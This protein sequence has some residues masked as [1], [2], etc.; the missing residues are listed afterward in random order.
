MEP[1]NIRES[2]KTAT[3]YKDKLIYYLLF[4]RFGRYKDK[5]ILKKLFF[6]AIA[7]PGFEGVGRFVF[8]FFLSGGNMQNMQYIFY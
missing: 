8:C 1:L 2:F 7:Y 5:A 6:F 3:K 4:K